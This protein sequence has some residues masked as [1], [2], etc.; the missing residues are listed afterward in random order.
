MTSR[1]SQTDGCSTRI[2]LLALSVP[3]TAPPRT[4]NAPWVNHCVQQTA[5]L[6]AKQ[7]F[8][9][10]ESHVS[11]RG[12]RRNQRREQHRSIGS[13]GEQR[14]RVAQLQPF[15]L[16]YLTQLDACATESVCEPLMSE[17]A[18]S[19]AAVSKPAAT[20]SLGPFACFLAC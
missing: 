14:Q 5:L 12:C 17:V 1:S 15:G 2:S 3:S 19:Y 4:A 7:A 16:G 18:T 6:F 11:G 20:G 10:F 8:A 13:R 9:T